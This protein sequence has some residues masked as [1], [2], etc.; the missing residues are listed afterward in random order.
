MLPL[1]F[2]TFIRQHSV[3]YIYCLLVTY[4]YCLLQAVNDHCAGLSVFR[5]M[6]NKHRDSNM[7]KLNVLLCETLVAVYISWLSY[8]LALYDANVLYRLVGHSFHESIW[9][10]LFGG[11]C[12]KQVV[13]STPNPSEQ[14]GLSSV[15]CQSREQ[16][17]P[18]TELRQHVLLGKVG[19]NCTSVLDTVAY[20]TEMTLGL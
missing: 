4:V 8:A 17:V 16:H 3:Y 9:P 15:V 19:I 18:G 7:P 6:M 11:C 13:V 20:V 1:T 2:L 5:A 12:K 14:Q 10:L